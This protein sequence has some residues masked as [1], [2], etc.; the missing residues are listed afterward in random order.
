MSRKDRRNGDRREQERRNGQADDEIMPRTS[1]VEIQESDS[2]S[3]L[4]AILSK[5]AGLLRPLQLTADEAIGLVEKL[6]GSVL[7]ADMRLAGETDDT[8]KSSVLAYIQETVIRREGEALRVEFPSTEPT[9]PSEAGVPDQQPAEADAAGTPG[10]TAPETPLITDRVLDIPGSDGHPLSGSPAAVSVD[11]SP[12]SGDPGSPPKGRAGS[13][14]ASA[15]PEAADPDAAA[16]EA[17]E[18]DQVRPRRSGSDA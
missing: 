14:R 5:V 7:D 6:Y 1:E 9:T 10:T 11:G 3:A 2:V 12:A 17:G 4:K 16:E 18:I 15:G 8:R 13:A